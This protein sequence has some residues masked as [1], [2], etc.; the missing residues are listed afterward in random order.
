MIGGFVHIWQGWRA[1]FFLLTALAAVVTALVWRFL[2]ETTT[3]DRNALNAR[4][5]VR[6]YAALLI[7]GPYL[8][9]ALIAAAVLGALFA[10]ITA[11]PFVLIDRLGVP[12]EQYGFYQAAIV[13]AYFFG[14]LVVNRLAGRFPIERLMG[15]GLVIVAM[16]GVSLPLVLLLGAES[17]MAIAAAMS[18]YAFGLGPVFATAPVRA[19]DT[20]P[21][22]RGSAAAMLGTME[23]GGCAAG[24]LAVGLLHDGTAWP[25]ALVVGGAAVLAAV[26][27]ALARPWRAP[28]IDASP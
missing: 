3:P 22:A 6:G 26:L 28:A 10:F 27:F 13:L 4:R 12:T 7:P 2:P 8:V 18:L 16:G 24:A 23:M 17:P 19:L 14:S 21:S 11:A 5:L 25:M 9:Y 1:N 20:A 15:A